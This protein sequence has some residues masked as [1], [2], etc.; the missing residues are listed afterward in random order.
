MKPILLFDLDQT[1]LNR[2]QS[3]LSFLNWQ[4]NFFQ[5]VPQLKKALFIQRFFELDQNGRVWKD[6][7]YKQ[8]IEEFKLTQFDSEF[9]LNSYINDFNK[10]CIP[11]DAVIPSI[12]KLSQQ[13]H[14]IGLI[15][16]GKTPFQEN[17]FY[18]LGLKEYFSIIVVSDAVQLRKPDIQIFEY[19][20]SKLNCRPEECIFIG[21]SAEA[22]MF[23]AK[24]A[25]MK[26]I[27]FTTPNHEKSDQMPSHADI[28][29]H[30]F[31]QL[32][33]AILQLTA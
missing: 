29:I 22:D 15:S 26:T 20:C 23:G 5:L 9:L 4:I 16:N 24:N 25:G 11:F 28:Q 19:A 32:E 17:N 13:G 3:L 12:Q 14:P 8:I 30:H 6:I 1:L 27:Y 21:D 10:F 18:A 33:N 31:D 7:V 2:N